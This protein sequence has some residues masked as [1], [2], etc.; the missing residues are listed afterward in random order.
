MAKVPLRLLLWLK[1]SMPVCWLWF[2]TPA[3]GRIPAA[4]DLLFRRISLRTA[5]ACASGSFCQRLALLPACGQRPG[6]SLP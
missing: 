5:A 3:A 6:R 2:E 1:S 4:L